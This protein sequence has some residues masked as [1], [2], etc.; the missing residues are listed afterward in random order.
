MVFNRSLKRLVIALAAVLGFAAGSAAR[1]QVSEPVAVRSADHPGFSRL[2]FDFR[3]DLP[4]RADIAGTTLSIRFEGV[5]TPALGRLQNQGLALA[6]GPVISHTENETVVSLTVQE[7]AQI[8][9]FNDGT[10]VVVDIVGEA[11]QQTVVA[12]PAPRQTSVAEA[13]DPEP[14]PPAVAK[15]A[16]ETSPA[17]WQNT[18][19]KAVQ[20]GDFRIAARVE[21]EGLALDYPW[22]KPVAASVFVRS[23]VLWVVFDAHVNA[24]HEALDG[25]TQTRL[26]RWEQLPDRKASIFRYH[27]EKDQRVFASLSGSVWTVNIRDNVPLPV[28][29]VQTARQTTGADGA[30]IFLATEKVGRAVSL[31]DPAIGDEIEVFPV[32]GEVRG[33]PLAQTFPEFQILATSQGIAVKRISDAIAVEASL[34]GVTIRSD[35]GLVLSES[36]VAARVSSVLGQENAGPERLIDFKKW[37]GDAPEEY[38]K[39]RKQLLY[40]LSMAK[41]DKR[42]AARWD[43]ARFDMAHGLASE[44]LAA[45]TL[46]AEEDESLPANP[47]FLAVRGVAYH[48]LGRDEEALK[49]LSH[50]DLDAEPDAFLWR[51]LVAESLGQ[52]KK[53]Q[54][55]FRQGI[56][57][58]PT[59]ETRERADFQLAAARAGLALQDIDF[60]HSQ[61]AIIELYPLTAAQTAEAK[62]LRAEMYEDLGDDETARATYALVTTLGNRMASARAKLARIEMDMADEAIGAD[63]AIDSLER[64]RFSWR[65]D[66]FELQLLKMLGDLYLNKD[67]YRLGLETLR[68]AVAH[69]PKDEQTKQLANRM[70]GVFKTLFVDGVAERMPP[71]TALALYYDFQELTPLGSAGDQMIRRL[72]DRLVEVDLLDRASELLDHQVRFRLEGAAQAQIAARLAKIYLLDGK[73]DMALEII[74]ATRQDRL[75]DEIADNRRMV[76]ARTLIELERYEEAGVLI[77]GDAGREAGIL[78]ADIEWGAQDWDGVIRTTDTL[79]G[80]NRWQNTGKALTADDRRY[81]L[82][83]AIAYA[84][85]EDR[86]GLNRLHDRYSGL[87]T[88]GNFA[89]AF[90]LITSQ[91]DSA[92]G[93]ISVIASNIASVD[94]LQSFMA[95]YRSEFISADSIAQQRN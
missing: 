9:S 37:A 54:A 4:Y 31:I 58:L 53:A 52:Y 68:Q 80:E 30:R 74:R 63:E 8:R 18:D 95:A 94:S 35:G 61:L 44:G 21:A 34:T 50:K 14:A 43:L 38:S 87:M 45:L 64:L 19:D 89:N 10:R 20:A 78:R 72:A 77:E 75:P 49:D 73:P 48:M 71:V 51:S 67:E 79:L 6:S 81:I 93:E 91:E 39:I 56:A 84:L 23:G 7:G 86:T 3:R 65:G 5:F 12:A 13:S 83:Q 25:L 62:Y 24:S 26:T 22:Q 28:N 46:M 88:G 36:T 70:S 29:P 69:F 11:G 2:V 66:D 1:A 59:Y 92:G 82:R 85:Q 16:V 76:E 15:P 90:E 17:P 27:L 42:N 41:A 47:Q 60:L 40:L 33:I 57:A 32:G 55:Y